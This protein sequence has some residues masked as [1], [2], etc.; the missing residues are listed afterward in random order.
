MPKDKTTYLFLCI[1]CCLGCF[2]SDPAPPT[3]DRSTMSDSTAIVDSRMPVKAVPVQ[4]GAFPIQIL[5][6]GTITADQQVDIK[7]RSNGRIRE[8]PI[9]EGQYVETGTL[10]CRQEDEELQIKLR[11]H[12]ALLDEAQVNL[13]EAIILQGGEAF[14]THS[15]AP[16][17]L[18]T[19]KITSGWNTLLQ[20]L[21]HIKYLLQQTRLQA[22]F[23]GLIAQLRMK[24]HQEGVQ[25][26]VLCTLI[27]PQTYE[28][29]FS[30]L[31]K[32]LTYLQLGQRVAIQPSAIADRTYRATVYRI[33]PYIDENGLVRVRASIN[34][35]RRGLYVGMK[36]QISIE[37]SLADQLMV[38][39][40]ALVLRSNREVIFVADTAVNLAK[41]KYVTVAHRND[42]GLAID[43]GL[44]ADDLVIIEGNLNL[45]HD[46]EIKI[47]KVD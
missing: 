24:Q 6:N 17:I 11:Q 33:D 20:Q 23:G 18:Q 12:R 36:C 14:D 8:L 45:A 43:E 44:E 9:V 40:G 38:P 27:N 35:S 46:A 5:S 7:L 26:D 41:W 13:N 29:T 16:P 10:L 42:H 34:G 1:S 31:E 25:G 37:Q 28:V 30:L 4:V 19:L 47:E 3:T 15:V 39:K 2:S 21:N 32:D 22:P